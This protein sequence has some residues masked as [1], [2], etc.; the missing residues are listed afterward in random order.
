MRIVDFTQDC[1]VSPPLQVSQ[2]TLREPALDHLKGKKKVVYRSD[3]PV[4]EGRSMD[5][6]TI[7]AS[8]SLMQQPIAVS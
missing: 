2:L 8:N 1:I 3:L 6:S 7:R 4:P 5:V